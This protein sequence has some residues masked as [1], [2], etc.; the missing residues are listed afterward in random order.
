VSEEELL[1]TSYDQEIKNYVNY[2][3]FDQYKRHDKRL[4]Y[5]KKV[6]DWINE[7]EP[8]PHKIVEAIAYYL[9]NQYKKTVNTDT[10]EN[11]KEE[12]D[13]NGEPVRKKQKK[14][15]TDNKQ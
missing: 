9:H 3:N 1:P 10:L 14:Y 11:S 2:I 7:N 13:D 5:L 8:P 6:I 12:K 4:P 15:H